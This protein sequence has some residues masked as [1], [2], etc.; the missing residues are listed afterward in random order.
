MSKV[1]SELELV[2]FVRAAHDAR[3]P[4]EI[5]AGATRRA[6]GNPVSKLQ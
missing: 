5:V 3:S 1:L 6:V 2:D 4:F